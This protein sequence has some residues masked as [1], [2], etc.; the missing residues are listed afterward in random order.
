M[1]R[2]SCLVLVAWF[3]SA[4]GA[5]AAGPTAEQL[6]FFERDIRPLLVAQCQKCHGTTK[7]QASLRVDS[8]E[9]L[10]R[11]GDSGPALVPG[12]PNQGTLLAAV[13]HVGDTRMPPRGKLTDAQI[14]ALT[15]WVAD[16]APWPKDATVTKPAIAPEK[17]WAF[18]PIRR[19]AVPA[20]QNATWARTAIDHFI[21]ARLEQRGLKP[22]EQ[23]DRRT[24]IRRLTF[25]LTGLPPTPEAIQEFL[26]DGSPQAYEKL[27]DRL[28]ASPAYGERWGRHWLDV[29]R[30]ADTAGDGADYPVR[31]AARYRNWVIRAF[32]ASQPFD[33]FIR[34]QIAGDVLA[35]QGPPE[36]FADRVTA[37]GF[38]AIGK[39][40]GYNPS[41]DFQHE[42]FADAID[43]VGRSLLGLS[44]GCAR[45]HDHKYDPISMADYYGLYGILQSSAWS[46]PGG[47]EHKKPARLIPLV[48]QEVAN[49]LDHEKSTQVARLESALRRLRL[50]KD[51]LEGKSFAGGV[52]L[53]FE[54]QTLGKPPAGVW[55]AMGPNQ[56]LAEAQSPYQ[57]IYPRG[58]RGVRMG[59]GLPTDGIRYVF[60]QGLRATPGQQMYFTIDFRTLPAQPGSPQPPGAYRFYVGRGVIESLALGCQRLGPWCPA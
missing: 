22:V 1:L 59:T 54:G 38:L 12:Q 35:R 21:L 36:H 47:E 33:E 41:T 16:G 6:A 32:N 29:A 15:R 20:V 25:D 44:V 50:E 18:Q 46:F 52:D 58:T 26:A 31:E 51:T 3:V 13:K 9:A 2:P 4:S 48:P 23:A 27:V 7:Q 24:L 45:C 8:R 57:H 11:G 39:R 19:P 5:T 40:Y 28:L 42:D 60:P 34:E 53:G 14:A 30:Y 10:L 56:V 55:L 43:S 37:T 49:R 17:H